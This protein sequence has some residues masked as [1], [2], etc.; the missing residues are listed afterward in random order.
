MCLDRY[1]DVLKEVKLDPVKA[2]ITPLAL[3]RLAYKQHA[4]SG[5]EHILLADLK[6]GKLTVS[7]FHEHY[8][9]LHATSRSWKTLRIYL[10]IADITCEAGNVTPSTIVMELEKLINFYRYNMWNGTASITHLLVNGEYA[11]WKN[12]FPSSENAWPSKRMY[13]L[14]NLYNWRTGKKYQ[15]ALTGQS[16]W[17]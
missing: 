8:P 13:W 7:I 5:K 4:F 6:D 9:A 10:L 3:Y 15:H 12:Y 11:G 16:G 1:E 2:D 14:K 17:H